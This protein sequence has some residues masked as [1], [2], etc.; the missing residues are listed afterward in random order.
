MQWEV[1]PLLEFPPTNGERYV[2]YARSVISEE[3]T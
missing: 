1:V 3:R 2:S